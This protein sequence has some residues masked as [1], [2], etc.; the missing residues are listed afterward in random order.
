MGINDRVRH[1]AVRRNDGDK[2]M[3]HWKFDLVHFINNG[4]PKYVIYATRLL[5]TQLGGVSPQLAYQMRWNRTV[6][7][8]EGLEKNI[9]M[10]LNNEFGNGEYKESSKAAGGQLTDATIERH[11]KSLNMRQPLNK[12]L[13]KEG[14][15][16]KRKSADTN[17]EKDAAEFAVFVVDG[18]LSKFTQGRAHTHM[19]HLR[20]NTT[21][22]SQRKLRD[23]IIQHR[24]TVYMDRKRVD[25]LPPA[26]H[27]NDVTVPAADV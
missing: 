14:E 27:D 21:P 24:N 25:M 19:E 4:H 11:S 15:L 17:V 10:D 8:T 13:E 22:K 26:D 6:K 23:K 12:M 1:R 16:D 9:E 3:M 5:I 20:L 2:M 7:V 18:E